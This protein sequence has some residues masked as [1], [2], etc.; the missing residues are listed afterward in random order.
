M[1]DEANTTAEKPRGRPFQPGNNANPVG[2]PKGSRNKL[3][4]AFVQDLY[5]DWQE[6]GAETIAKVR[7]DKPDQYLKVVAMILPKEVK[8]TTAHDDLNDDQ[9]DERIRQIAAA[10]ADA[11]GH[12]AG[13]A[14]AA[15]GEAAPGL[16]EQAASVPTLQ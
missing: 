6:H 1:A 10:V 8:V 5:A 2:R 16:A 15:R 7:T 11:L 12:E 13:T 4:E 14:G 3:G 9:L